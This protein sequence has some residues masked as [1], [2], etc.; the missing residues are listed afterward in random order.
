MKK[1]DLIL[2]IILLAAGILSMVGISAKN[3]D[4]VNKVAVIRVDNSVVS[5]IRVNDSKEERRVSFKFAGNMGYL[6]IKN[7]AV[8]MEEM[9][10]A[11]CPEKI[12]SDTGWISK[13][14][15]TI[16]CLPNK[17]TVSF[18]NSGKPAADEDTLDGV[19]Y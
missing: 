4:N 10:I 1:N 7:G 15:Q 9:D 19:S 2:I 14:Y 5:R 11:I 17:I 13:P 18:E 12:C 16:V 3:V 8:K 6:D